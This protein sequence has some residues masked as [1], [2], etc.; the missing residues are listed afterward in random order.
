MNRWVIKIGSAI[1]TGHHRG[2]NREAIVSFAGQ[3]AELTRHEKQLILVSSGSIAEG[4]VRLGW[5]KRPTALHDLQAAAAL[6]QMGL[7]EA[8][9]QAFQQF[10]LKAAQILLTH[11]DLAIRSRYLN[12]RNTL[13]T[14]LELGVVPIINENDTVA[15]DEI[16][17]GDND[18]LA[19][20][21]TNLV[22]AERLVILT[23]QRG[24]FEQDPR[25]N[26]HARL[27]D[28]AKASDR[29]LDSMA[30]TGSGELGRGGMVTKLQAARLAAR[31][32]AT[33]H[34]VSGQQP[35]VLLR[36]DR[37]EMDGTIL[38]PDRQPL[39]ARK[40]WLAGHLRP[41]GKVILDEGAIRVL[42]Q[43]GSSLLAVG[44]TD[45][46]GDFHTGDLV[47]CANRDGQ[48]IARG[49]INYSAREV[50]QIKGLPSSAIFE[51]LGY[52]SEPELIHRDN[53]VVLE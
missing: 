19:G 50:E 5:K 47:S 49:L 24:L 53:L 10:G 39:A 33:T 41:R 32:G 45:I 14:L 7:V 27:V 25:T 3:I 44:V 23:D 36:L 52:R 13:R 30:I 22:E 42:R 35:E 51:A 29:S 9:Q 18:N 17:F 37:G 26:P 40:L 31:S 6:G 20:M 2:I 15:T 1:L 16:R 46:S 38:L 48:E 8:W 43:S 12:A 34:I 21:V 28:Q 11:E 4:I